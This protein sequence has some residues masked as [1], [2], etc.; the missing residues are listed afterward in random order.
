M[1]DYPVGVLNRPHRLGLF[2]RCFKYLLRR[3]RIRRDARILSDLPDYLLDDI[4]L[5][6]ADV[7]K[8]D[9]IG[10]TLR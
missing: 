9:R 8:P 6:R 5:T 3:T 2:R 7:R 4:G 10:E 1:T